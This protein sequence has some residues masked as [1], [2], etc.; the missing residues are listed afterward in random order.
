MRIK[1]I[2]SLFLICLLLAGGEAMALDIESAAFN[3]G[4][5]M[6]PK[7]TCKGDDMS[8]QL[9]WSDIPD[10]TQSLALVCDDPDAPFMTWVHWVVYD[11]PA[12]VTGLPEAVAA[13]ETL[14]NGAKQGRNDFRKIGYG[15][16]CPPPGG[17]HRYYFK[18]YALDAM[19]G[20]EPGVTKKELLKAMEGHVIGEAQ[21]IGH[22]KR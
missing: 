16:P 12:T 21:L 3:D 20:L 17:P 7:Y 18:L 11:I 15:G 1:L 4:D 14:A 6:D 22:F 5:I 13:D 2:V 8:P 19:L 10:G 9:S